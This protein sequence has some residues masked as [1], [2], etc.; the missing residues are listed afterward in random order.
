MAKIEM[1]LC[2]LTKA[3][4]EK[5]GKEVMHEAAH[6]RYICGKCYRSASC[7]KLICKPMPL[8]AF[9][10]EE[11][12]EGPGKKQGEG[13]GKG[14]REGKEKGKD[15][16]KVKGNGNGKGKGKGKMKKKSRQSRQ[17]DGRDPE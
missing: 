6:A 10:D 5:L 16:G 8:K 3:D 1:K 4:F 15:N 13:T 14:K 12:S 17:E 2:K 11:N 7:A 9:E